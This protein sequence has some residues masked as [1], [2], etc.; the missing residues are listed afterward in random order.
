MNEITKTAREDIKTLKCEDVVVVR[1]GAND[2]SRNNMKETLKY[3]CNFV[4]DNKEVNIVL[5]NSPHRHDLISSS[6]VNNEVL[7]FNRQVK[8]IMKIHSNVK[9]F[10]VNL[11]RKYFTRHGQYI[12]VSGK[13]LIS[14][15]LDTI[16]EQFYKK[17]QLPPIYTQWEDSSLGGV[18]SENQELNTKEEIIKPSQP[19]KCRSNC[20]ASRNPDFL[21][22]INLH[23]IN[24]DILKIYHQNIRSTEWK[25]HEL[26]SHLYPDFPHVLCLTEHHMNKMRLNH[27]HIENYNLGA[28]FCRAIYEKGGA[29][30]YVH[31][32]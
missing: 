4:N 21:W 28:Q 8:K 18:T 12:N 23:K 6:C 16:I 25:T 26:L 5:I 30:I 2:I 15:K 3:V 11:E 13:E 17:N 20:P 9:L 19:S 32:S 10:E 31:N 14:I 22:T 29:A 27:V 1:G 7:K 24:R